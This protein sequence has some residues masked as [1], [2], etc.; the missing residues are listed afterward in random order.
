MHEMKIFIPFI[1]HNGSVSRRAVNKIADEVTQKAGSE[2]FKIVG[3]NPFWALHLPGTLL[4]CKGLRDQ[5]PPF[6]RTNREYLRCSLSLFGLRWQINHDLSP[7]GSYFPKKKDV[8][9]LTLRIQIS[10]LMNLS[11]AWI[12]MILPTLGRIKCWMFVRAGWWIKISLSK[13]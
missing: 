10:T 5:I 2:R 12:L 6:R 4:G 13:L 9:L 3:C 8:S 7:A 11:F 1:I